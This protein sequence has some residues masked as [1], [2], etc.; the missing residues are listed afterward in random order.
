MPGWVGNLSV[1][2]WIKKDKGRGRKLF[3]RRS[4]AVLVKVST[5]WKQAVANTDLTMEKSDVGL[6]QSKSAQM[7]MKSVKKT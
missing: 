7:S 2:F 4:P 5:W 1:S 3:L 6:I